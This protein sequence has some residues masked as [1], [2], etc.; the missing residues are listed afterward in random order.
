VAA[1]VMVAT[2]VARFSCELSKQGGLFHSRQ[3]ID[4]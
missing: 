2:I 1:V 3:E 4:P